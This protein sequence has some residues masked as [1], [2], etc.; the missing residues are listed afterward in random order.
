[1]LRK[2]DL[3]FAAIIALALAAGDLFALPFGLF[4]D[5]HI[6]DIEPMYFTLM[7]NQ[8]FLIASAL[9][10]LRYVC[11]NWQLR[12]TRVNFGAGIRKYA[13]TG[14]ILFAVSLSAFSLGLIGDYNYTPTVG[15]VLI[16]GFIYYLGVGF[17]EELYVRGLLLNLLEQLLKNR[18]NAAIIAILVSAAIFSLGHIPGMIGQDMLTI[19]CRLVWTMMLGVYLGVVYKDTGNLWI[20]IILHTVIDF[21]GVPFCFTTVRAYPAVAVITIATV[22]LIVGGWSLWN[23]SKRQFR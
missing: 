19:I 2:R 9:V 10:V 13:L 1:M 21:C 8:W 17:I 4:P 20:P 18:K 14:A 22:Y 23:Y 15:K 11:P 3:I 16:E 7:A 5:I 12:L 6:C